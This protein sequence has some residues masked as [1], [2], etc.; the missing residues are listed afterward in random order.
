MYNAGKSTLINAITG[1]E[2]AVVGDV[3]TTMETKIFPWNGYKIIDSP[4]VD[5]TG[6]EEKRTMDELKNSNVV[7]FVMCH[8][9]IDH[10][11]VYARL[12]NVYRKGKK[13]IIALNCKNGE[14]PEKNGVLTSQI[15][16]NLEKQIGEKIIFTPIPVDAFSALDGKKRNDKQLIEY[17][18]ILELEKEIQKVLRDVDGYSCYIQHLN[19][20]KELISPYKKQLED[21]QI[22]DKTLGEKI[23]SLDKDYRNF[24]NSI[25]ETVKSQ[26]FSL[27]KKLLRIAINNEKTP[28]SIDQKL[29]DEIKKFDNDV[30]EN[31]KAYITTYLSDLGEQLGQVV[32]DFNENQQ[33]TIK[34]DSGKISELADTVA[35]KPDY[36][37]HLSP[38]L[39]HSVKSDTSNNDAVGNSISALGAVIPKSIVTPPIGPIPPIPVGLLVAVVGQIFKLFGGN[40]DAENERVEAEVEAEREAQLRM[41]EMREQW[42]HEMKEQCEVICMDIEREE[43]KRARTWIEN[44]VD[45]YRKKAKDILAQ[46]QGN[47][48]RIINDNESINI[49][50]NNVEALI[51]EL[52]DFK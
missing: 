6:D 3:P 14:E 31:I 49:W 40:N 24:Y 4:G 23:N 15:S 12:E 19:E 52:K 51:Y 25:S 11:D 30:M 43:I 22:E 47:K 32:T 37:S 5:V 39:P 13:I 50:Y 34:I 8:G 36:E 42:R 16:K 21:I 41:V 28:E 35:N 27:S 33:N 2:L 48:A 9:D 38:K 29:N 20:I 45:P 17:S 46:Y 44:A 10:A 18:N 26:T 1:E 7:I